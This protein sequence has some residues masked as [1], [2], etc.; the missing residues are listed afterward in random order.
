MLGGIGHGACNL[1]PLLLGL[2]GLPLSLKESELLDELKSADVFEQSFD[3][4][5]V[6]LLEFLV[7]V[8]Y[9]DQAFLI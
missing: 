2:L 7:F 1:L 4:A 8:T 9:F 6:V 3:L 5:V